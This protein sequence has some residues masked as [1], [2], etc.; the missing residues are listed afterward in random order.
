MKR[1]REQY[2]VSDRK[3]VE[4]TK[5][6]RKVEET[7][8]SEGTRLDGVVKEGKLSDVPVEFNR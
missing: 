3:Q 2:S 7:G 1:K 5:T 6:R 8:L 4:K